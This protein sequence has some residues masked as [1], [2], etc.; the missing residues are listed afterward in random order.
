MILFTLLGLLK[1]LNKRRN[2]VYKT[3]KTESNKRIKMEWKKLTNILEL[4]EPP[5]SVGELITEARHGTT[6]Q[7]QQNKK[8]L[9]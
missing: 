3:Y 4:G 8:I 2:N 6:D 1:M 7:V 5:G 9:F